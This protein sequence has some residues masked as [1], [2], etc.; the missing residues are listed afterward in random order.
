VEGITAYTLQPGYMGKS[1]MGGRNY[2]IHATAWLHGEKCHG[3]KELQYTRYSLATWGKVPWVEGITAY[4][5]Q[6]GYM[7]K[8]AMGGRN[9]SIHATAWLHG[10]KCHGWKE[11]QH[12]HYSLA[13]LGKVPWVEG[14]TAYTLQLGYMVIT[15]QSMSA[16]PGHLST[17]MFI[18]SNVIIKNG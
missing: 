7:G 11:L 15:H 17:L 6:P 4:T 10:E 1:A 16:N 8:S 2:S 14:I 13:T 5:L 3:W 9:Y 18:T 12:T